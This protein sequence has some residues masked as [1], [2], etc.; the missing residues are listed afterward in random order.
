VIE[1]TSITEQ[2]KTIPFFPD[3]ITTEAWVTMGLM[4]VV[5]GIGIWGMIQPIGLEEPADPMNTPPHVKAHWYFLFLQEMLKFIPKGI[6]VV[7]PVA[8]VA[9]MALLPFLDRKKDSKRARSYRMVLTA[10][11]LLV[12]GVLTYLGT[13]S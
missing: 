3:H 11:L 4:V 13:I 9:V 10:A 7:I 8:A 2:E 1:E 5:V 12:I 6:G